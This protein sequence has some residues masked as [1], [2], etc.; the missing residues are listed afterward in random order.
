MNVRVPVVGQPVPRVTWIKD[1][2]ELLTEAGRREVWMED[3]Y[4]VLNVTQCRRSSDRGD[5]GIRVEN[6]LGS[7]QATFTVEITGRN[8]NTSFHSM[9][10]RLLVSMNC[11]RSVI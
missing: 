5:Y 8:L 11:N 7:D 9:L 6:S 3:S 4:A 10:I 1:G 2:E